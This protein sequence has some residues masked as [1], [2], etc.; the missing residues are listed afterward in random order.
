MFNCQLDSFIKQGICSPSS[1]QQLI[2]NCSLHVGVFL[3]VTSQCL[4]LLLLNVRTLLLLVHV[5]SSFIQ[6][7]VQNRQQTFAKNLDNLFCPWACSL[8]PRLVVGFKCKA[9]R[10]QLENDMNPCDSFRR[11]A[12][13]L[14]CELG[15]IGKLL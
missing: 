9:I 3:S 10:K 13:Y 5:A 8:K 11:T 7:K 4:Y 2:I 15:N 1:R 6:W 12:G 14:S